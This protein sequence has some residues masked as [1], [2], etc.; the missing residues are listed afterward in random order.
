MTIGNDATRFTPFLGTLFLFILFLNIW[1]I[2]P[3]SSSRRPRVSR[4]RSSWR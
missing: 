2:I 3:G 4:S 1:E